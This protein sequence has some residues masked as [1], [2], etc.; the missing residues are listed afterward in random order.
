MRQSCICEFAKLHMPLLKVAYATLGFPTG[1]SIG[2]YRVFKRNLTGVRGNPIG[3]ASGTKEDI[4]SRYGFVVSESRPGISWNRQ[5]FLGTGP[6]N[7]LIL[8]GEMRFWSLIGGWLTLKYDK[9]GVLKTAFSETQGARR[10]RPDRRRW[11]R[12]IWVMMG[13]SNF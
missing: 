8:L 7:A 12:T 10:P 9:N 1:V 2:A 13:G 4:M 6:A 5:N 11:Y 3:S